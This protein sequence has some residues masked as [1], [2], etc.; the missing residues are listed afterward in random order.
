M[1]FST[2]LIGGKLVKRYHRFLVDVQLDDGSIV[3]AHCPN[4]GTMVGCM[5]VGR[6]VLLSENTKAHRRNKYTWEMIQVDGTWIGVNVNVPR[7]VLIEALT[8]RA[9]PSLANY[10]DLTVDAQFGHHNKAD[11]M[12]HGTEQN[13]FLNVYHIGWAERGTAK[14][15]ERPNV[16]ARKGIKELTEIARQG[17]RA[18]G[19]FFAQRSDCSAFSPAFDV[20][21]EF[22]RLFKDAQRQ[23]VEIMAYR[24]RISRQ[25]ISLGTPLSLSID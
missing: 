4:S 1:V 16:R 14:F 7:K 5:E 10:T 18:V 20:D 6:P 23:G 8:A 3:T 9:I 13:V 21:A 12:L 11:I 25:G 24:A 17:H 2:K 15:P 22:C 19:V